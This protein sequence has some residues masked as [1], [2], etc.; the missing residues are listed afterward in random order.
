M[1][2]IEPPPDCLR[3]GIADLQPRNVPSELISLTRRYS[4][5][6]QSS[7]ELRTPMPAAFRRPCRP[8]NLSTLAATALCQPASWVTSRVTNSAASPSSAASARPLASSR[9]AT[10]AL[11]PS[12]ATRRAVSAPMPD[13]PPLSSTTLFSRRGMALPFHQARG[14]PAVGHD[15]RAGDEARTVRG[16]PQDDLAQIDRL[17]HAPDRMARPDERLALLVAHRLPQRVEDRRIDAAGMHRIAA[18]VVSL[19]SAVERHALAEQPHRALAGGIGGRSR[20]A[21]QAGD[22]RDVD[23][24]A[25]GRGLVRTALFHALDGVLAAQE[26]AFRI[27]RLHVLPV[28]DGG[29]LHIAETAGDAGI[30][31]HDVQAAFAVQYVGEQGLP[32]LLRGDIVRHEAA[33][34]VPGVL[35]V[36]DDNARAVAREQRRRRRANTRSATRDDGHLFRKFPAHVSAT[37]A[38]I[39]RL[40]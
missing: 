26:H 29:G 4:A 15:L 3:A 21:D 30:V 8:P 11:P 19:L 16:E 7:I 23:D 40:Q 39:A 37:I 13:A 22:R 35:E 38:I 1:L 17:G 10:T 27:D 2:T 12:R 28:L 34:A 9:S 20:R 18:D 14:Q 5:N 31:D 24:R 36:G 6:V 32:G 33:G 25:L